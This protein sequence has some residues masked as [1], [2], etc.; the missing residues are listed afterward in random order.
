MASA[1]AEA[2]IRMINADIAE[3][4][5]ARERPPGGPQRRAEKPAAPV[6]S[7]APA[8]DWSFLPANSAAHQYADPTL[9]MIVAMLEPLQEAHK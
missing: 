5:A 8:P 2:E 3:K 7:A 4:L 1:A 9:K 6:A